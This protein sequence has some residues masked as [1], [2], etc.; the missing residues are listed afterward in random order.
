MQIRWIVGLIAMVVIMALAMWVYSNPGGQR[1]Q[2][3]TDLPWQV[4]VID[5]QRTRVLG[6]TLGESTMADQMGRLPVPDIRLFVD[7]DGSRS[8]EAY[9]VNARIPPFETN[10]VLRPDLDEA[11][12]DRI[13]SQTT[14]DRPMPSGAWRYGLSDEALSSLGNVP[15]VEMSYIPVRAG[16]PTSW[17]SALANRPSACR[18]IP[19]T[20]TGSIPIAAWPS[21][22]RAGAA[23]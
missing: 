6:F 12:L 19:T 9:Y 14:S 1:S 20:A 3:F 17:R 2:Q 22:C 7:P 23:C 15:I 11:E 10:L 18:W 8:V 5:E 16:P 13:E 4:Q 21:W